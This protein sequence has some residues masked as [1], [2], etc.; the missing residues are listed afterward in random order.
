VA[1]II[2]DP[3]LRNLDACTNP[4]LMLLTLWLMRAIAQWIQARLG[5]QGASA[6]IADIAGQVL[7]KV[8]ALSGH[9]LVNRR[10]DA[11]TVVTTGLDAL[12]PYFTTY[13]PALILATVLTPATVLVIAINDIRS[14]ALV[15]VSLPLI[16][17]FMV[18]I[19]V[20]T[21]QRSAAALAA[22]TTLQARLLDLITGIPTL[23]ALGR[24]DGPAG[25]IANLSASHRRS[26]MATLRIAFLS[27]FVM[28]LIAT[29][30]VALVAV[31]IGLRLVFGEMTLATGLTVLLLAPEVFWPLRRVGVEFHTAQNGV[32]ALRK[33]VE[34]IAMSP[35][36]PS[37]T[38]I[39]EAADATIRLEGLSADGRDGL[40]PHALSGVLRPGRVTVLTGANGA[41]KSTV[42]QMIAGLTTPSEGRVTVNGIDV[43]ELEPE[44][45]WRQLAWLAQRP[46]LVP[47]T[48]YDNLALFGSLS[49]IES[50]CRAACFD[51]VLKEVPDGLETVLGRGGLGLSIGQRQRLAIARTL[52]SDAPI[53]LLD[54]PTAHLDIATES[55]VLK[56]LCRRAAEGTTIVLVSHRDQVI[57][58]ADDVIRVE[59][60]SDAGV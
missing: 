57:N 14:G 5:Q 1:D 52:G 51:E 10:D 8:T 18:L 6:A 26:A 22:M 38:C 59:A 45:W 39:V 35:L 23:R 50:C 49:D 3:S 32:A 13:L 42:L 53:L 56:A 47:G 4:L 24:A 31:S 46:V 21:A 34:L 2:T 41:G 28:E 33:A 19:G 7:R 44:S 60:V 9:D 16:P 36:R 20:T 27:A 54:E 58:I 29:L 55:K 17:I 37:G 40:A 11:V 48:I 12:R 25:R 43:T 15:L 30:G